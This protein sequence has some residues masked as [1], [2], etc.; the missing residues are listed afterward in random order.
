MIRHIVISVL[1]SD[2]IGN[3]ELSSVP[4]RDRIRSVNVFSSLPHR[5]HMNLT[6]L[7]HLAIDA[8][9]KKGFVAVQPSSFG[10]VT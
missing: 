2:K 7:Q 9:K 10:L 8:T 1:Y 4:L 5:N 6:Y 3:I